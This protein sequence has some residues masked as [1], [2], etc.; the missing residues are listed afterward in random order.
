MVGNDFRGWYVRGY[1]LFG[2]TTVGFSGNRRRSGAAVELPAGRSKAAHTHQTAQG[3]R[4]RVAWDRPPGLRIGQGTTFGMLKGFGYFEPSTTS[5]S[6][7]VMYMFWGLFLFLL[8]P[9]SMPATCGVAL[10]VIS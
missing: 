9:S 3:P 7:H 2:W 8:M 6:P 1:A 4:L 5:H 10:P